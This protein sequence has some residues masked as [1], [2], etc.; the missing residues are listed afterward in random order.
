[1][2][3]AYHPNSATIS[4]YALDAWLAATVAAWPTVGAGTLIDVRAPR[5]PLRIESD[6]AA[7]DRTTRG[8]RQFSKI[9]YTRREAALEFPPITEA[10]AA[11]WRAFYAATQGFRLPFI[12]EHP[13]TLA[14]IVMQGAG[15]F[16]FTLTSRGQYSGGQVKWSERL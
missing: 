10:E 12:L 8:G 5:H 1:M 2:R 13:L 3:I 16:P 4:A 9:N 7:D 11:I 6:T 14:K 15:P